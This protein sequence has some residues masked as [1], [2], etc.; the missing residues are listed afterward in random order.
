MRVIQA[1]RQEEV[2]CTKVT[3]LFKGKEQLLDPG[4]PSPA[5]RKELTEE[6]E[7]SI[8][9][10]FDVV[11]LRKPVALEI[12]LSGSPDPASLAPLPG[13][14]HHHFAYVLSEHERE[15]QIFL[16]A[17]RWSVAYTVIN[18]MIAIVFGGLLLVEE[19]R[20]TSPVWLLVGF[21]IIVLTWV[22][23]W[24]TYEFFIYDGLQKR[25]RLKLLKKIIGA[26]IRVI[27][28]SG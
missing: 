13:V 9:S 5:E 3:L 26:E 2:G 10:N 1:T 12:R 25:H 8:I 17:R 21:V 28:E 16:R 22:T 6:A 7:S 23:V 19:S 18:F 27:P 24:D 14:I 11:P 4:D 15:V 20:A